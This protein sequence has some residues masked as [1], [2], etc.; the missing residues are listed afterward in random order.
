LYEERR[1][2]VEKILGAY[3]KIGAGKAVSADDR[4][5][6]VEEACGEKLSAVEKKFLAYVKSLDK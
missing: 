4:K 1:G 6:I 5:R 3:Q 2:A